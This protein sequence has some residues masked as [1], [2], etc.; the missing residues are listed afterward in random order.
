MAQ[1]LAQGETESASDCQALGSFK[2]GKKQEDQSV[3]G[4]SGSKAASHLQRGGATLAPTNR[5][6]D[7]VLPSM[8]SSEPSEGVSLQDM[9]PGMDRCLAASQTQEQIVSAEIGFGQDSQE[10]AGEDSGWSSAN[11]FRQGAVGAVNPNHQI[12]ECQSRANYWNGKRATVAPTACVEATTGTTGSSFGRTFDGRGKAEADPPTWVER[13]L[14][15]SRIAPAR[16]TNAGNQGGQDVHGQGDYTWTY[17]QE[18]QAQNTDSE[19][20]WKDSGLGQ[21]MANLHRRH[22]DGSPESC[23]AL[24]AVPRRDDGESEQE[25]GGLGEDQIRS[26]RSF[27]KHVPCSLAHA[28]HYRN[29][30]CSSKH[31]EIARNCQLSIKS[32]GS[33]DGSSV[34]W[35]ECG[36]H[37]SPRGSRD[38]RIGTRVAVGDRGQSRW[39][40]KDQTGTIPTSNQSQQGGEP[41][42]ESQTAK[43]HTTC[44]RQ[45][46]SFKAMLQHGFSL[47]CAWPI[48]EGHDEGCG[49]RVCV[50][51][52][53]HDCPGR[54]GGKHVHF[55]DAVTVIIAGSKNR[56]DIAHVPLDVSHEF[57]RGMWSLT[58]QT[59]NESHVFQCFQRARLHVDKPLNDVSIPRMSQEQGVQANVC[60]ERRQTHRSTSQLSNIPIRIMIAAGQA[61]SHPSMHSTCRTWFVTTNGLRSV[62]AGRDVVFSKFDDAE[63]FLYKVWGQWQDQWFPDMRVRGHRIQTD[64]KTCEYVVMLDEGLWHDS[65]HTKPQDP[66]DIRTESGILQVTGWSASF[67]I[68]TTCTEI[69]QANSDSPIHESSEAQNYEVYHEL[70]KRK[71]QDKF[72]VETWFLS[73]QFQVLCKKSRGVQVHKE[74]SHEDFLSKC[75][76][77]WMDKWVDDDAVKLR[78]ISD[79]KAGSAVH[80]FILHGD[81]TG[82]NFALCKAIAL[83]VLQQ[84]RGLLLR[85][86]ITANDFFR[87]MYIGHLCGRPTHTCIVKYNMH[88]QM[89]QDQND[90]QLR[91]VAGTYCEAEIHLVPETDSDNGSSAEVSTDTGGPSSEDD[92]SI[93]LMSA[94]PTWYVHQLNHPNP[95]PWMQ[96]DMMDMQDEDLDD[97]DPD[98]VD[99]F[100]PHHDSFE[101]RF[102]TLTHR[103]AP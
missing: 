60:G 84:K 75:R 92:D 48:P 39:E 100:T 34:D 13:M 74:D 29:P 5:N 66:V 43:S 63:S 40:A 19:H 45:C 80:V 87:S 62:C 82:W 18:R 93:S 71:K 49:K 99:I 73:P 22:P 35:R 50:R 36:R 64:G 98:E 25:T 11:Y 6:H 41:D 21:G 2:A 3:E 46:D 38:H 94:R 31:A 47:P 27:Q 58:N 55:Q 83:P 76:D 9:W 77:V 96:H 85:P 28:D 91:M 97:E 69:G 30:R 56:T 1:K 15:S 42:F 101:A 26:F 7:M 89:Q 68:G 33:R 90:E 57:C 81:V 65:I 52:S 8:Q 51:L 32:G 53:Q 72:L 44:M 37:G 88:R 78:I 14:C 23:A 70:R 20:H 54:T 12:A 10:E 79:E 4:L 59:G 17:Q 95:Y 86:G 24:S 16:V 103:Q 102:R 67:Q 61:R